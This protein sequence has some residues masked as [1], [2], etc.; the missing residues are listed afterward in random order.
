MQLCDFPYWINS[1]VAPLGPFQDQLY[2]LYDVDIS[3]SKLEEFLY[4]KCHIPIGNTSFDCIFKLGRVWSTHSSISM[5][6]KIGFLKARRV[7]V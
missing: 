1:S 4:Q 7:H 2:S 3:S 5:N 6:M